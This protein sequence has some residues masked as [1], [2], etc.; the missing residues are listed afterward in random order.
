MTGRSGKDG[1]GALSGRSCLTRLLPVLPLK[2]PCRRDKGTARSG[3]KQSFAE[4][5]PGGE[6]APKDKLRPRAAA[7][8]DR[9][10]FGAQRRVSW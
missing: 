5:G 4:R 2:R 1:Y 9:G 3:G 8:H 6:D 7:A 10:R